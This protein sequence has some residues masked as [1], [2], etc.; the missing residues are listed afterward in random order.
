MFTEGICGYGS[1]V[2]I[3]EKEHI[4]KFALE[5]YQKLEIKGTHTA[6]ANEITK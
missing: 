1:P 3:E 4:N 5:L 2:I 6:L